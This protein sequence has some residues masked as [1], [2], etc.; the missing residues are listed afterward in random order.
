MK[1]KNDKQDFIKIKNFCSIKHPVKRMEE[2]ATEVE[3]ILSVK[4]TYPTQ[5]QY[6][7]YIWNA[8]KL[9]LKNNQIGYR[10][11][12]IRDISLKRIYTWQVSI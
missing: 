12:N 4:N 6:L 11:K 1:V 5:D 9:T 7:E 2:Q 10:T 8:E 3:K